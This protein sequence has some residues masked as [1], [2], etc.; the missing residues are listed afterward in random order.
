MNNPTQAWLPPA[1]LSFSPLPFVPSPPPITAA[2]FQLKLQGVDGQGLSDRNGTSFTH[3][4]NQGPHGTG[5][6]LTKHYEEG[7]ERQP[8]GQTGRA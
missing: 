1:A 7:G 4:S 2:S 8:T 5:V 3:W 6:S